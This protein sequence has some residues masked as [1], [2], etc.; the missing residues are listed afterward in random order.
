MVGEWYGEGGAKWVPSR[1]VR[2]FDL[3]FM[4]RAVELND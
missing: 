3:W 4:Y 2:P 1:N